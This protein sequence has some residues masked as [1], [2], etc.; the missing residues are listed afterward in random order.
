MNASAPPTGMSILEGA[1][2]LI[3]MVVLLLIGS[4]FMTMGSELLI[5]VI[6]GAA[7]VAGVSAVRH[8]SGWREIQESTGQKIASVL[9]AILILLGIGMLIGSWMLS[10]TIPFLVYWGV[11]LVSPEHLVLTAFLATAVMS[12]CTGTSWG[13]AGTIGVALMGTAVA[14]GAPVAATAGAVVSGSYFGDKLSPLS[15]TTN[16]CAI[17]AG[18]QL[19][20]HIKHLLYTTLPSFLLAGI[21]FAFVSGG[22]E[23]TESSRQAG[24]LLAD[25]ENSFHMGLYVLAPPLLILASMFR[26]VPPAVAITVSAFTAVMVGMFFQDS[27]LQ[28][29]VTAVVAGFDVSMIQTTNFES[30]SGSAFQTLVQRGGLF[31]MAPTLIVIIAAFLLAG[32]M[33]ASGALKLL[34][35]WMLSR[36]RSTFGLIVASMTSGTVSVALTSH[37]GVTALL[38]GGLYQKAFAERRLAPVNLSRAL[39]D[40]VTIVEPL[41]PWTVSAI[42]MATTLGVDTVEYAPWAIFCFA[43]PIFSLL[44]GATFERTGFGLKRMEPA[45]GSGV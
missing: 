27:T 31:S 28:N 15:D 20:D 40:S 25:L 32:A 41:M 36:V 11:K 38:V 19:Y 42:F 9:P 23:T 22:G 21:I 4:A 14:I 24:L 35:N 39:E 37:A 5:V 29:G 10:G 8:G 3:V 12:L 33:D 34:L 2:P 45:D 1:M 18:A 17:G 7:G 26:K 16:I 43:G 30:S 44:Y 13:S 6:L